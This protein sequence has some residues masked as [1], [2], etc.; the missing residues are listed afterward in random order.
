[1]R[2][3]VRPMKAVSGHNLR[4]VLQRDLEAP[5]AKENDKTETGSVLS[6]LLMFV[7]VFSVMIT[8]SCLLRVCL[9]VAVRKM[10]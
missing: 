1:V 4:S 9:S 5:A 6:T 2:N 10:I 7:L 8:V 3:S